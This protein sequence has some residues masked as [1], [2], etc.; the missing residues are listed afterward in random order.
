MEI[1]CSIN[2]STGFEGFFINRAAE[3][4]AS[5][6][7]NQRRWGWQ[8]HTLLYSA[9]SPPACPPFYCFMN[10]WKI[11]FPRVPF[12]KFNWRNHRQGSMIPVVFCPLKDEEMA[13]YQKLSPMLNIP[14]FQ[15]KLWLNLI[16]NYPVSSLNWMKVISL[17]P[18]SAKGI[19]LLPVD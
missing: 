12:R 8:G 11:C 13:M 5:D 14:V 19:L 6:S 7:D 3:G 10:I 17:P 16:S 9:V 18:K 1:V 4:S 15:I 2:H